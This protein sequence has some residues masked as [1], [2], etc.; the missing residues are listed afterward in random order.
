MRND[1]LRATAI[2]V[3]FFGSDALRV[4]VASRRVNI[5]SLRIDIATALPRHGGR[6]FGAALVLLS[7]A[8]YSQEWRDECDGKD[9]FDAANGQI[10]SHAATARTAANN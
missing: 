3:G 8:G 1:S 2:S 10:A 6:R 5:N 4:D 9:V 7:H